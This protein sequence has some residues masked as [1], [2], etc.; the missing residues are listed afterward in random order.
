[1]YKNY[2]Q[3]DRAQRDREKKMKSSDCP[4]FW[5]K[6]QLKSKIMR[7]SLTSLLITGSLMHVGATTYAQKVS[8]KEKSV[9]LRQVFGTIN[10]QTGYTYF[11]AAK[12][13]DPATKVSLNVSNEP[14]HETLGNV[15]GK[16][17]LEFELKDKT[18]VI[19]EKLPT[20]RTMVSGIQQ[21]A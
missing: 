9:S 7:I 10:K 16:L 3:L 13:I 5:G 2:A 12:T 11:W 14:L 6:P 21:Y 17:N 15:L 18:I 1:M 8:I 4:N 20:A 19:R